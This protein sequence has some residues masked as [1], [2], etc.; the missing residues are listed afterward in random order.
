MISYILDHNG[1]TDKAFMISGSN[2]TQAN[3]ATTSLITAGFKGNEHPKECL[4]FWYT[5]RVR[6]FIYKCNIYK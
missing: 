6:V 4:H 2:D 3:F 5:I 1:A